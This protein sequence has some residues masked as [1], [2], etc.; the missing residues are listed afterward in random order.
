[1][2]ARSINVTVSVEYKEVVKDTG[3]LS[4]YKVYVVVHKSAAEVDIK[5]NDVSKVK[6]LDRHNLNII[7]G[8]GL[9]RAFITEER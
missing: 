7:V 4:S 5:G 3:S 8:I 2:L 6:S 9:Y 1:M